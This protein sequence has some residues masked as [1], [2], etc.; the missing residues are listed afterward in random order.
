MGNAADFGDLIAKTFY[1]SGA[2]SK[3][4]G[5]WGGGYV[6]P[7][8]ANTNVIQ[9]VTIASAGD[10]SDFGDLTTAR[11]LTA[12]CSDVHGGLGD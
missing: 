4:R 1:L 12:S 9:F 3:T 8:N 5:V 6:S 11:R 7:S 2:S 10:A